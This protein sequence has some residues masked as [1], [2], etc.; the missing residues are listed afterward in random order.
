M[1]V[2]AD[3]N[4]HGSEFSNL[5]TQDLVQA[6]TCGNL[7]LTANDEEGV[8]TGQFKQSLTAISSEY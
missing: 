6:L 4:T 8:E 3:S 2:A 1:H 7:Q 5:L